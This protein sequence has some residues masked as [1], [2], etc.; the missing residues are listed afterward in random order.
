MAYCSKCGT[1][2]NNGSKFCPKCGTPSNSNDA[3]RIKLQNEC[4][5]ETSSKANNCLWI[6]ASIAVGFLILWALASDS[7]DGGG[8]YPYLSIASIV[9]ILGLIIA[10]FIGKLDNKLTILATIGTV[11]YFIIMAMN[12]P[13]ASEELKNKRKAKNNQTEQRQETPAER[14]A[15]EKQEKIKKIAEIAYQLGYEK[16]KN[17]WGQSVAA[18]DAAAIDYRYRYARDPEDE[19]QSE[20]WQVFRENYTKGFSDC[21]DKIIKKFKEE[22]L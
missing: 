11:V 2:L 4:D 10:R 20:R 14:E 5:E 9:G 3:E 12:V 18:E 17:T 1:E 19:G 15:N 13:T 6:L 22:E 16:R 8:I 21:A 7:D